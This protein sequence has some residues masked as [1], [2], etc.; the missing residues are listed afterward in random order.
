MDRDIQEMFRSKNREILI[1]NLKY[2]LDK[3]VNSLL[4]TI[5]NIYKKFPF[6]IPLNGL[7]PKSKD[8]K[9]PSNINGN[10]FIAS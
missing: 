9:F 5:T 4:D 3:N 8:K 10:L 6:W 2:D 1:K 7:I